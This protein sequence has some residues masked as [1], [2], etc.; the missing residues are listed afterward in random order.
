MGGDRELTALRKDG[1]EVPVEVGLFPSP[2][3]SEVF[4]TVIDVSLRQQARDAPT[5]AQKI[6]KTGSWVYDFAQER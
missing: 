3:G 6:N 1:S 4:V 2:T 5:Q